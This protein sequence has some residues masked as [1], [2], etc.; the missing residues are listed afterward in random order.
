MA[1][2]PPLGAALGGGGG[3]TAN[4]AQSPQ[5]S[6]QAQEITQGVLSYLKSKP[7]VRE[8]RFSERAG[9][10][11]A[12]LRLWERTH[13]P[14]KLPDDL[15]AFLAIS[16]GMQL[17][18][19]M[20]FRGEVRPLGAMAINSLEDIKPLPLDTWPVDDDGNDD[21]LRAG[22]TAAQSPGTDRAAPVRAF[23][24]DA[25]CSAG[26][27]AL[28]YGAVAPVGVGSDG[29]RAG[30][31]RAKR[32]GYNSPA[33]SSSAGNGADACPQVWFQDLGCQ[34]SFISATFSDY[35]RL[36]MMHLG[37]P[38]WHYAFT[39]L[40]LDPVAKQW[41]R[42]LTPERLAIIQA[43]RTKK[44]KAKVKRKKRAAR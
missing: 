27:V 1:P 7:G 12:E 17:T 31:G 29:R 41:F 36:M 44:E 22:P 26:R 23:C 38:H 10:G 14:C 2:E 9:A 15:E 13:A 6:L 40:G 19:E 35:F 3:A 5:S 21:E 33:S 24:L 32:K 34:W 42:Y 37:L 4:A 25:A 20:E 11:T 28:V 43:E 8:V 16:N 39:E 18:W 30:T